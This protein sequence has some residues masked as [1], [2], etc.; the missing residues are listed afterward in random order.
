[1][2]KP[3]YYDFIV[4]QE[5]RSAKLQEKTFCPN[6]GYLLSKTWRNGKF[7][8]VCTGILNGCDYDKEVKD[9]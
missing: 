4:E 6:C 9:V 7:R 8:F 5:K 3:D 2:N 1:M